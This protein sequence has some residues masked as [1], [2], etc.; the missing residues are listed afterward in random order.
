MSIEKGIQQSYETKHASEAKT[1]FEKLVQSKQYV[2]KLYSI[3]YEN[4]RVQIH[5]NERHKVGGIPSLSFLIAT[6]S[7]LHSNGQVMQYRKDKATSKALSF[8]INNTGSYWED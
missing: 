8:L 7:N 1:W 5:D 3:N 4:A 6:K 2:G